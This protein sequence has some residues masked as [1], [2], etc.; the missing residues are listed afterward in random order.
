MPRDVEQIRDIGERE[1]ACNGRVL[2]I[3]RGVFY[4]VLELRNIRMH[5]LPTN[6]MK[7][8]LIITILTDDINT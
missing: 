7:W 4:P 1:Q 5:D 6:V 2:V 3:A 8:S